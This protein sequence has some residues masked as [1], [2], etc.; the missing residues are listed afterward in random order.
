MERITHSSH[1]AARHVQ[2]GRA[3]VSGGAAEREGQA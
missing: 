1:H 3:D 2:A